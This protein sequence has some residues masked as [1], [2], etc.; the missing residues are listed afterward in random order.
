MK[1]KTDLSARA[2]T[3]E[4]QIFASLG[5][6]LKGERYR[7]GT[8]KKWSGEYLI[9]T[10]ELT[11]PPAGRENYVIRCQQC[12]GE[13]HVRVNSQKEVRHHQ[14]NYSIIFLFLV[15][16]VVL[17]YLSYDIYHLMWNGW[18]GWLILA[19]IAGSIGVAFRTVYTGFFAV[20]RL[21]VTITYDRTK[22]HAIL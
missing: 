6:R 4:K 18:A 2:I 8:R 3:G 1:T 17:L 16:L 15:F 19:G 20:K 5:H 21:V 9:Q 11:Q 22:R 7:E 10:V 12:R 14:L 13:I